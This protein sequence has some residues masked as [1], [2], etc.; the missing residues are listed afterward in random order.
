MPFSK[1][2]MNR[3]IKSFVVPVVGLAMAISLVGLF[4]G[5]DDGDESTKERLTNLSVAEQEELRRKSETFE[6]LEQSER[7]RMRELHV[8]ITSSPNSDRLRSVML[9]YHEWLKTLPAKDRAELLS[10][11]PDQRLGQIKLLMEQQ[12]QQRFRDLVRTSLSPEDV[13]AIFSWLDQYAQNHT[14]ELLELV[15][16]KMRPRIE[17]SNIPSVQRKMLMM[18]VG[19][20]GN[21]VQYPPPTDGEID[22]L[23][24][25]LSESAQEA[26]AELP[27]REQQMQLVREWLRA[28]V[29]SRLTPQVSRERLLAFYREYRDRTTDQKRVEQLDS[30]PPEEF[31]EEVK[32]LYFRSRGHWRGWRGPDHRGPDQR[33]SDHRGPDRDNRGDGRDRRPPP[34]GDGPNHD[35]PRRE[36]GPNSD[37]PGGPIDRLRERDGPFR[38]RIGPRSQPD[39][40]QADVP[41]ERPD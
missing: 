8:A 23:S 9:K 28:S 10:L 13:Q 14:D 17:Q 33:G 4:A 29:A 21:E 40:G 7:D 22:R 6:S 18:A 30:L 34:P 11:P 38:Q 20:R 35:G 19:M 41:P 39:D 1:K 12:R 16:E 24:D 5:A 32:K 31:Y 3:L 27:T 26:L 2:E 15:P 37:G 25:S 36:G